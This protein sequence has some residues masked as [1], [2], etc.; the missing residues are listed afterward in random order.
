MIKSGGEVSGSAAGRDIFGR[1]PKARAVKT[2]IGIRA[3]KVSDT[4]E[5]QIDEFM[6][7]A[8]PILPGFS[9]F[10]MSPLKKHGSKKFLV[11]QKPST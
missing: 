3:Q 10:R 5:P 8:P 11:G 4:Q 7:M 6:G 1:K 9:L 2:E